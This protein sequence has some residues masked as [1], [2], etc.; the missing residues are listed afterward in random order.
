MLQRIRDWRIDRMVDRVARRPRGRKARETYGADDVHAFAWEPVL[1]ALQLT[2]DDALL[3]VGCGGGVFLR[4]ALETGCGAVGVDHSQDMVHLA[5]RTTEGRA[6]IVHASA[7]DLPFAQGS[8][9]AVSSIVAFFF[10][11]DPVAALREFERVVD[12]RRGRIVVFTTP[13]ELKGTPAA[14]YPLATRGRFYEDHELEAHA[15]AAGFGDVEVR[16]VSE[17]AQLLVARP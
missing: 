5:R 3:D 17:G 2:P 8:F 16:R 1:E 11:P 7:D 12:P 10:F 9:T 6:P 15:G 14:P 4:R 13:P